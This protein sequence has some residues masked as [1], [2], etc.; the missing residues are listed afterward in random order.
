MNWDKRYNI[1]LGVARALLYLH[2]DAP[3]QIIHCNVKPKNILLDEHMNPILSG[4]LDSRYLDT[5]ETF[6]P[7]IFVPWLVPTNY[8]FMITFE[9]VHI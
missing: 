3:T 5:K 7:D 8:H 4:F 6:M 1:I 2:R 9:V